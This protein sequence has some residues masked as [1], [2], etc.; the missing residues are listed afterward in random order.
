M[1]F[2]NALYDPIPEKSEVSAA[3]SVGPSYGAT[4]SSASADGTQTS[5]PGTQAVGDEGRAR[6]PKCVL[7]VASLCALCCA[8]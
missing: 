8:H 1:Y 6:K 3:A 2:T 4:G 7:R 5:A